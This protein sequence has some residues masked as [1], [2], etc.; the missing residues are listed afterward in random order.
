MQKAISEVERGLNDADLGGHVYKKRIALQKRGKSG[1]ARTIIA[2]KLKNKAFFIYG[3]AKN[4]RA[5]I[6]TKELRALKLLATHLLSYDDKTLTR[7]LRFN[8]LVE[9]DNDG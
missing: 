6:S 3:F 9:V 1:G 2:F 7:A 4:K 8:E 5:N